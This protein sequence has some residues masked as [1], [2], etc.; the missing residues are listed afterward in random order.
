MTAD[1]LYRYLGGDP[2][3]RERLADWPGVGWGA[4][5]M[6]P[7]QR[8]L[9]ATFMFEVIA[10]DAHTGTVT[11]LGVIST[12][13]GLLPGFGV[14]LYVREPSSFVLLLMLAATGRG[15]ARR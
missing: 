10:I 7:D 6:S 11:E 13:D 2:D 8:T 12:P 5:T 4:V 1:G 9:Y 3:S 15:F 14:A